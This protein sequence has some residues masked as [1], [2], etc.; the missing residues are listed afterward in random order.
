MELTDAD[1][2]KIKR[3]LEYKK[4]SVDELIKIIDK[5]PNIDLDFIFSA[6]EMALTVDYTQTV[7]QAVGGGNYDI[8][9]KN[10]TDEKIPIPLEKKGR[11]EKVM[12]AVIRFNQYVRRNDA[13]NKINETDYRIANL[14][15]L[16]A[17]GYLFPELQKDS[18]IMA[19][20][21]EWFDQGFYYR[22]LITNNGPKRYIQVEPSKSDISP[23]HY[24]WLVIRK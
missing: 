1:F 23:S 10:V 16:L 18:P 17:L 14:M 21:S 4:M 9:D 12:A 24:R 8:I 7:A 11:I 22:P 5:S 19:I 20:G 13:I 2:R 15:E 6:P 3:A